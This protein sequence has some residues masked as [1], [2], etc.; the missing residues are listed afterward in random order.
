MF[1]MIDIYANI[2]IWAIF[3]LCCFSILALFLIPIKLIADDKKDYA[4]ATYCIPISALFSGALLLIGKEIIPFHI[5]KIIWICCIIVYAIYAIIYCIMYSQHSKHY[6]ISC[7]LTLLIILPPFILGFNIGEKNTDGLL[8]SFD[9]E[10]PKIILSFWLPLFINL[11]IVALVM[12]RGNNYIAVSSHERSDWEEN[13]KPN[14]ERSIYN[15]SIEKIAEQIEHNNRLIFNQI[16]DLNHSIDK[17]HIRLMEGNRGIIKE[18][19]NLNVKEYIKE[20]QNDIQELKHKL[21]KNNV[22]P[23]NTNAII[24]RELYHFMATPLATIEVN[25]NIVQKHL[26]QM[27]IESFDKNILMINTAVNICKGVMST[28]RELELLTPTS[29]NGNLHDLIKYSFELYTQDKAK[30]LTLNLQVS[31]NHSDLTN[32]YLMSTLLPLIENAVTAS[33][34]NDYVEIFENSGT[35][36]ISNSFVVKPDLKL[37]DNQGYS[38]KPDHHGT[39]LY[40]V[41]HLLSAR[42]LGNL[43]YYIKNDRIYFEIPIKTE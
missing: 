4:S 29:D 32:F 13:K 30:E 43:S 12:K 2:Y 9:L 31:E 41:R 5:I 6:T 3:C 8:F 39:G 22:P 7:L 26:R 36:T 15:L 17:I 23:T 38:S 21:V 34:N 18:Q 14:F 19:S 42:K 10:F 35:I 25:C 28:Y 27:D 16:M 37:F 33:K 1:C 40:I 20:L 24:I 11:I